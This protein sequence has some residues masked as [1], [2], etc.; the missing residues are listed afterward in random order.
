ME[1]PTF[2]L[3]NSIQRSGGGGISGGVPA[4]SFEPPEDDDETDNEDD[5]PLPPP[6]KE[7]GSLATPTSTTKLGKRVKV[8]IEPGFSQ[9]DWGRLQ[10]SGTDLRVCCSSSLS[11]S[12]DLLLTYEMGN[13]RE[14]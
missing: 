12:G 1:P 9:L 13:L 8:R 10:R 5:S 2:P 3:P 14:E 7:K 4:F 11:L 6:K